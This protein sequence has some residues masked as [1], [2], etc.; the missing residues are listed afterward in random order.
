M[1]H[2]IGLAIVAG[3][4]AIAS[5]ASAR[6]QQLDIPAGTLSQ[7]I[8]ALGNQARVS[9]VVA[10]NDPA[11]WQRPVPAI[12]GQM[13]VERALAIL[14][15]GSGARAI[16]ASPGVWRVVAAP[17]PVAV[18][19]RAA[20]KRTAPPPL[21]QS[22]DDIVVTASKRDARLDG[23]P[24]AV[25]V[26][27]G[28]ELGRDGESGS[29]A[30]LSRV[31]TVSS[32]YLGAGRNKLFIRG[33][34]DSS[35]TGP[36]QATVGQYFGDVRLT[37]NAPDPDL[38]LYD[39]DSVEILEGP[40][41]TLYG[42]G[43]LGGIIRIV[44]N[45]PDLDQTQGS[46]TGGVSA[47]WHGAPGG[48][49]AGMVNVPIVP[50]AIGL[51]AVAYGAT[52]GGYIDDPLRHKNDVNRS[53]IVGGRAMLRSE[54]AGWT[55]DLGGTFQQ[56]HNLDSQYADAGDPPL[57]RS[58]RLPQGSDASY[59]L[60]EAVASR[61]FG[62]LL[63]VSSL[64]I[65]RQRL[66]ER[67]D[68]SLPGGPERL[69]KQR[70]RTNLFSFENRLSRPMENGLGWVVGVSYL[71]NSTELTRALGPPDMPVPATGVTNRITEATGY[72]EVSVELMPHLILTGGGRYSRA[73]LTG[74]GQDVQPFIARANLAVTAGRVESAFLPSVALS[75]TPL[76]HL[77]LYARYQESFRPGGL[78][79]EGDFVRR[80]LNDRA[81]TM[82]VG[83]RR[84]APETGRADLALSASHTVWH[85]IQ[86][87]YI[88]AR[89]LPSTANIG[90]GRI[91]SISATAGWVPVKG[92]RLEGGASINDSRITRPNLTFFTLAGFGGVT[93]APVSAATIAAILGPTSQVPNIANVVARG[94]IK[95]DVAVSDGAQLSL[96]AS[97]RYT[98][99]SRLGVGPILGASQGNY[100][101]TRVSARLSFRKFAVTLSATNLTDEVGNRFALGTPFAISGEQQITPLRPRTVRLGFDAA[102]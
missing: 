36:T 37:Y 96:D 14:L 66:S 79:I 9:V 29:D 12:R 35:F 59:A 49:L 71:R 83:I 101:D 56:I 26:L 17:K 92:L 87:D 20:F 5:P 81:A 48:D 73:W 77:T 63:F 100:L 46:V 74:E 47:T 22:S 53:N 8:A 16:A 84:G 34:A 40:Q 28:L 42:A 43:S 95:Y 31:T 44:R 78:A 25:T 62:D 19:K 67:Y 64:G 91:W 45:T 13:S 6:D 94:A 86:A 38:R 39:V 18:L 98:G 54:F 60:G 102:F 89:G 68:A 85:N 58:S 3:C 97:A 61:R 2:P 88:D 82:E 23:Y 90:D 1:K 24:G 51:R 15:R 75:A 30:V 32:T 7:A 33:I 69:F 72:G 4:C 11:L 93:A 80:F 21:P 76:D 55:L 65:A 70:N 41:G 50:G 99:K 57:T 27:G 10:V 52:E